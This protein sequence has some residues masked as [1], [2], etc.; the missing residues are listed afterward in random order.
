MK[1]TGKQTIIFSAPP[2]IAASA[3]VVGEKEGQGPLSKCFDFVS[4]DDYFGE[5]SWEKAESAMLT[6]CFTLC[7]DQLALLLKRAP[8]PLPSRIRRSAHAERTVDGD[9]RRL[10][11]PQKLR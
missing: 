9:G 11:H 3:A 4:P 1:K 5:K 6:R 7:C 8:V 10:G 2:V